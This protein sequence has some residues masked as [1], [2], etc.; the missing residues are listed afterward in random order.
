MELSYGD[1]K[2]RLRGVSPAP[3]GVVDRGMVV[4]WSSNAR[5]HP[6]P[7]FLG[8]IWVCLADEPGCLRFVSLI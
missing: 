1:T 8:S 3:P 7:F 6:R 2:V 4:L 5:R